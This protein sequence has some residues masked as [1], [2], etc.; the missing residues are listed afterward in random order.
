M[1]NGDINSVNFTNKTSKS[2]KNITN[3]IKIDENTSVSESQDKANKSFQSNKSELYKEAGKKSKNYME[4][5]QHLIKAAELNDFDIS[6]DDIKNY[7]SEEDKD[8]YDMIDIENK[9]KKANRIKK[10]ARKEKKYFDPIENERQVRLI[11]EKIE[12]DILEEEKKHPFVSIYDKEDEEKAKLIL[13][14][15]EFIKEA[16]TKGIITREEIIKFIDYY[17]L[18]S[19]INAY[20]KK[21]CGNLDYISFQCEKDLKEDNFHWKDLK[22]KIEGNFTN[23]RDLLD[24]ALNQLGKENKTGN[25]NNSGGLFDTSVEI[26]KSQNSLQMSQMSQGSQLE[27][28]NIHNLTRNTKKPKPKLKPIQSGQQNQP[29]LDKLKH[30]HGSSTPNNDPMKS[31]TTS[32][33]STAKKTLSSIPSVNKCF[34]LYDDNMK[35]VKQQANR[36]NR[37]EYL[38][39][40]YKSKNKGLF[41]FNAKQASENVSDKLKNTFLDLLEMPKEMLEKKKF[42]ESDK[43]MSTRRKIDDAISYYRNKFSS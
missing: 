40:T 20:N 28:S 43:K 19:K 41:T 5:Y 36:E 31:S 17:E 13:E 35:L 39:Q 30:T 16:Y 6:E 34:D 14:E 18:L 1:K 38:S 37:K 32:I 12:R 4:E 11:E 2:N 7:S 24:L 10:E 26:A 29:S 3:I 27:S 15:D 22:K 42:M 23:K 8:E 33:G 21:V 9:K 25:K